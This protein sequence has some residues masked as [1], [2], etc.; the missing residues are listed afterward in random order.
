[1]NNTNQPDITKGEPFAFRLTRSQYKDTLFV[2]VP[3]NVCDNPSCSC[4]DLGMAIYVCPKEGEELPP[5]PLYT[6]VLDLKNK[7]L[8]E[9]YEMNDESRAFGLSFLNHTTSEHW[10]LYEKAHDCLKKEAIRFKKQCTGT[11]A[12]IAGQMLPLYDEQTGRNDPCPC[13]SGK[14]NKNCCGK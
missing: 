1:M 7:S 12:T 6:F 10:P 5:P 13:G 8:H 2:C 4:R 3:G 9:G 11:E 14:K